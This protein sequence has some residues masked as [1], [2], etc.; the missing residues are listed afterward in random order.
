M[1]VHAVRLNFSYPVP[2]ES[3]LQLISPEKRERLLKLKHNE[4]R[5]R[6]LFADLLVRAMLQRHH[7]IPNRSIRFRT[8]SFGKPYLPDCPI[9]FNVSHAGEWAVAATDSRS[10]GIDIEQIVPVDVHELSSSF[11]APEEISDLV[12]QPEEERLEAFFSI[13][14]GKES[15]VKAIGRGLSASL[16]SFY[17]SRREGRIVTMAKEAAGDGEWRLQTYEISPQY[18]LCVCSQSPAFPAELAIV[19]C[20]ELINAFLR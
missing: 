12:E 18:R 9:Q 5:L 16:T 19:S 15:Y 14:T 2:W 3:L 7:G 4:D 13:W 6:G 20:E 11:F 10:I 17:V 1:N 8:N